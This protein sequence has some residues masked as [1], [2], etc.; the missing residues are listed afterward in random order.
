MEDIERLQFDYDNDEKN[1][2]KALDDQVAQI[3]ENTKKDIELE[4]SY[5]QNNLDIEIAKLRQEVELKVKELFDNRYK[6]LGPADQLP[7]EEPKTSVQNNERIEKEL[8][9]DRQEYEREAK[10]RRARFDLHMKRLVDSRD[11]KKIEFLKKAIVPLVNSQGVRFIA[12]ESILELRYH[13]K[14][15]RN[16]IRSGSSWALYKSRFQDKSTMCRI[17]A[18]LKVPIEVRFVVLFNQ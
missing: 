14:I 11:Q 17:T 10:E 15:T 13:I 18:L 12:D 7:L 4:K 1:M 5:L 2:K 3:E 8:E 6:D 9:K 16:A